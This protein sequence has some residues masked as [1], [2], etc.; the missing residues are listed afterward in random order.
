LGRGDAAP[1]YCPGILDT[2]Q[3]TDIKILFKILDKDQDTD[4]RKLP[5]ILNIQ[6]RILISGQ[7]QDTGY[8]VINPQI[9]LRFYKA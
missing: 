8:S 3:G 6:I 9:H 5:R 2:D 7:T 4:I 1:G